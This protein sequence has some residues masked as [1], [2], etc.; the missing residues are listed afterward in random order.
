M[1]L[2]LV[3]YSAGA[4]AASRF[5]PSPPHSLALRT[6]YIL[7]SYPLSVLFALT[8]LHSST[9]TQSLQ[10]RVKSGCSILV[11]FGTRDQFTGVDKYRAWATQLASQP[12]SRFKAVEIEGA[13]HF[14]SDKRELM[15]RIVEYSSM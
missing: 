11:L 2:L 7:L 5:V 12:G 3:G 15:H 4:L 9:F 1:D 6:R 13:D 8:A 14:W 10:E